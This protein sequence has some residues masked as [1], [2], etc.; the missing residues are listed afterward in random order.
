MALGPRPGV[1][2][3]TH[4]SAGTYVLQQAEPIGAFI[5]SPM[6]LKHRFDDQEDKGDRGHLSTWLPGAPLLS[7]GHVQWWYQPGGLHVV[8]VDATS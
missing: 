2:R 3:R 1:R 4:T 8:D 7:F 6:S 5:L